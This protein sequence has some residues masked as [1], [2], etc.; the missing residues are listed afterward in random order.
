M[1]LAQLALHVDQGALA[2]LRLH[3]EHGLAELGGTV[4]ERLDLAA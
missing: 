3:D 1:R 4:E 2:L